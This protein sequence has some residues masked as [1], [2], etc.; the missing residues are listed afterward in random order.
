M[1]IKNNALVGLRCGP[2]HAAIGCGWVQRLGRP[3]RPRDPFWLD[4]ST[5]LCTTAAR[6]LHRVRS[7]FTSTAWK[8]GTATA[9]QHRSAHAQQR[10]ILLSTWPPIQH[11]CG[12]TLGS[13]QPHNTNASHFSDVLRTCVA[14]SDWRPCRRPCMKSGDIDPLPRDA[15]INEL[16]RVCN[17]IGIFHS[18]NRAPP[19]QHRIFPWDT[20]SCNKVEFNQP[21][22][23]QG[24]SDCVKLM[25]ID[26]IY[27]SLGAYDFELWTSLPLSP[28]SHLDP[29]HY[30]TAPPRQLISLW[31]SIVQQLAGSHAHI[32]QSALPLKMA[33]DISYLFV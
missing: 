32:E 23:A 7:P 9:A 33:L 17:I 5:M 18:H 27:S 12:G 4:A 29:L 26:S 11:R 21:C 16:R 13:V 14:Q 22:F 6:R 3:G 8:C 19:I 28:N 31:R 24:V 25:A 10:R 2:C 20:V 15:V 1:Q 30:C